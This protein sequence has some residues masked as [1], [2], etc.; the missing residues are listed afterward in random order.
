MATAAV[1]AGGA[2]VG[3]AIQSRSAR[4][5]ADKQLEGQREGISEQRRAQERSIEL[6]QPFIDIGTEAAPQFQNFLADPSAGLEDI[7][8]IVSFLRDQGFEQIQE[9]AAAR[10][11]LG[12]GGTLQDLAQFNL[13]L[14]ANIVPQL[15]QQRFNELFNAVSLGQSAAAGQGQA[16]LQTGANIATSLGNIGQSQ[17]AGIQGQ[18]QAIT[19]GIQ[20]LAGAAG[21][22]PNLFGGGGAA[23]VGAGVPVGQQVFGL[24]NAA[25]AG[26]TGAL[27][28][29]GL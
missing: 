11:R 12:A 22:F 9:S 23:P 24:G 3:S 28:T 18:S 7:S 2:L 1:V 10:G 4:K 19:G 8:P 20:N 29:F 17:A 27:S 26:G 6:A 21:A 5:A 15:R 25:G 16:A 13:D 14:T